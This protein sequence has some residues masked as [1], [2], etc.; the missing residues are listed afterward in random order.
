[1]PTRIPG[2]PAAGRA[3]AEQSGA[4]P[5]ARPGLL[6]RQSGVIAGAVAGFLLCA[7]VFLIVRAIT[8]ASRTPPPAAT[9]QTLC[10]D[11]RTQHYADL[12]TQ[13]APALQAAGTA[14]QFTASQ[15]ELDRLRGPVTGCTYTLS[16]VS[17]SGAAVRFT[18]TRDSAAPAPASVTLR[19]SAGVW[20]IESYDSA[21]F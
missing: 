1:M 20:Q 12:Y 21:E 18:I 8:G 5:S 6:R 14:A 3:A 7:L 11:L 2:R 4:V 13:L 9:A 17:D 15:Q 16:Q 19:S 10:A